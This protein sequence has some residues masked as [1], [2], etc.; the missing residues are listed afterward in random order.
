M[1][2][3]LEKG[4]KTHGQRKSV[5]HSKRGSGYPWHIERTFIQTDSENESRTFK[6][7]I[8]DCSRENFNKVF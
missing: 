3:N 5:L 1:K 6:A 2:L 4:G 7:G 8:Y